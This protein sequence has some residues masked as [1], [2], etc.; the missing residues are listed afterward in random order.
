MR[1]VIDL[2]MPVP[3]SLWVDYDRGTM[4]ALFEATRVIWPGAQ[5]PE[6]CLLCS[7]FLNASRSRP[8][9][10]RDRNNPACGPG[11][12]RYRRRRYAE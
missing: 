8:G 6:S 4:F 12:E 9:L 10:P 1:N 7:S 2:D 3:D 11:A 5:D